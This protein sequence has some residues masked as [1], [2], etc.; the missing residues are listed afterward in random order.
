MCIVFTFCDSINPK[1]CLKKGEKLFDRE[2]ASEWFNEHVRKDGEG[3]IIE[4]IPELPQER[5]FLFNGEDGFREETTTEEINEFIHSC[6]PQQP[7]QA[8]TIQH[9]DYN[10]YLETAKNGVNKDL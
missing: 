10:A 8:T 6:M 3:N 2:Y 4:G 5:F 9:F 7:E 1:K